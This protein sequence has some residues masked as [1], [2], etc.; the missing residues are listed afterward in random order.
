MKCGVVYLEAPALKHKQTKTYTLT[1][2]SPP[3]PPPNKPKPKKQQQKNK[4]TKQNKSKNKQKNLHSHTQASLNDDLI[5][6]LEFTEALSGLSKDT[7]PGL[8]KFK[9]IPKLGKDHSKLKGYRRLTMQNTTG[10]LMERIVARKF[11]RD[12][13]RRNIPKPRRTQSRQNHLGKRS[14][15]RRRI[16]TLLSL[17]IMMVVIMMVIMM[18]A[19]MIVAIMVEAVMMRVLLL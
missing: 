19:V 13:E 2:S 9:P 18:V 16:Y 5:T 7:A 15:I 17:V 4:K 6:E 12:L 1:T 11:A 10:K 3:P 8:D 14:Q